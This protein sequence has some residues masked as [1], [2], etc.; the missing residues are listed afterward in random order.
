[1]QNTQGPGRR[2]R[3]AGRHAHLCALAALLTSPLAAGCGEDAEDEEEALTSDC[4]PYEATMDQGSANGTW[5]AGGADEV[6]VTSLTTP[7]DPGGGYYRIDLSGYEPAGSAGIIRV[8]R[9]G[10]GI[11]S[12]GPLIDPIPTNVH[13]AA[14]PGETYAVSAFENREPDTAPASWTATWTFTSLVDCWEPNNRRDEASRFSVDEEVE[15][16]FFGG[17]VSGSTP[18]DAAVADW[19]RVRLPEATAATFTVDSLPANKSNRLRVYFEAET[20]PAGSTLSEDGTNTMTVTLDDVR[21][22]DYLV[23]VTD[24]L[25]L[26]A[27]AARDAE[28]PAHWTDTYTLRVDVQP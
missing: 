28:L 9:A 24:F 22:G 6:P 1:M 23:E 17:Y 5:P 25:A 10:E 4:R 19:Y 7:S 8:E 27:T 11:A 12:S 14:A 26:D 18:S 16:Y 15:A 2:G 21:A 3:L 20:A 13:F